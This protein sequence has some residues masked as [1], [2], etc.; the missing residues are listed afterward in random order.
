MNQALLTITGGP[1]YPVHFSLVEY[2]ERIKIGRA[3]V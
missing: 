3:H 1:A 2:I